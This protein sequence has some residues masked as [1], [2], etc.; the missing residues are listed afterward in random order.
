M[1]LKTF[2]AWFVLFL[3]LCFS[4]F[5][6]EIAAQNEFED[7]IIARV[8]IAFEGADTDI[9]ASNQ[10]R[11]IAENEVGDIY[12]TV[13]IRNALQKLYDTNR[14]ASARVEAE[15]FGANQVILRF[16]VK[17][18]TVAKRINVRVGEFTGESVTEQELLLRL[19]LSA[20]GSTITERI[21]QQNANAILTY[22]RD[23][24]FFEAE[25]TYTQ[26]PLENETEVNVTFNVL[27]NEQAKVDEF[28]LDIEKFD[29]TEV[30]QKIKLQKGEFF[31]RSKLNDDVERI[32][33]ALQDANFLAPRLNEPRVIYDSDT[34]TVD[35]ELQGEVGP[36]V[37]VEVDAG[38]EKVGDGTQT[39]LLP[40]RRE[41]TL[42]YSAIV[43]GDRR[44]ENY[45]QEKGYFFAE[46]TPV[47]SVEPKFTEEEASETENET[48][49]LCTA[50]SG[51]ELTD[52][53]VTVRYEVNLNRRLKLEDLRIEGTD[54]LTIEDVRSIL[55]SQ[56]ANIF[57][58]IP[59][60]GYGRGYTS[61]ELLQQDRLT[62]LSL[63][64]ELGYRNAQVAIRQGVSL[65]GESLIVTFLVREGIPTKIDSIEI[66]GNTSFSDA[67]LQTELPD[68][69]GKNFS[70]ARAR[71]SV[72][73]LSQFYANA[74]Y[75]DAKV[76]FEIEEIPD[77]E[78]AEFDKVK[79]IFNLENEGQK[80][81][82]NR[83][84]INGN[85]DTKREAIL[86]AIDLKPDKVLRQSDIFSSEQTL[87]STDAFNTVEIK[88]EP[89][90]ETPD[91][92]SRLS[93][94]IV[95]VTEKPPRLITYGGG[96]ST[97]VGL[98]GFFDI[99]HFNLFGKLQQG[100]ALVR[101][102]QRQQLVQVDFI[103]PR[104]IPDGKDQRGNQQ[105]APLRFTAQYQRD[106]TVTRFF[107]STFDQGTFGIVQRVD[108]NGN[109]I[110]EFG[111]DAGDPTLNRFTLTA[112]TN[113]TISRKDRTILFVKYRFE[114]VRLFNFESLLI[115]ELLRPDAKIRI[116]GFGATFVRDTRKNCAIKYTLIEIIERGEA[117]EPC[118]YSAGDPTDGDYLTAEYNFSAPLLGANIGFNKLQISYNR[119]YTVKPLR[120][121]TF[122]ARGI[123]GMAK[124]FSGDD[125]FD[126]TQFPGLRGSLPISERFFAGGSTT[127]R[128]FEFEQAGPRIV[129]VPEGIF[130]NRQGEEVFLSPFS[131]PFGGNALA[132]VNLEARVPFTEAIRV[133]PFYDGGNVFNRVSDIF[134]PT[135][136]DPSD[137][138]Q[139]NLRSVWTH[140]VGLGFRIKTPI[141]GEFAVDYGYLLNPPQF[142]IP[143]P[144]PPNAT[145]RL[146][147]GQIHFRFSQA[148]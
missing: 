23:R 10:F 51:A 98:S 48:E 144:V 43:E 54:K 77:E 45:F 89:A 26:Q 130:R 37:K 87:Y 133:V 115:K 125:R 121:T 17:R 72:R 80:V 102:S 84:L 61:L 95:N 145:L 16:V 118:R 111:N 4:V 8:D 13:S 134:N 90:G 106:S 64:R 67:T 57:G 107:R 105:F 22:L 142:T 55:E 146:H 59:F 78:N 46:A 31:T 73:K 136:A 135:D 112:E 2:P 79:L 94:V 119:Y 69:V 60:F 116:S 74:G 126:G 86:K 62:I 50:L 104:F 81:F 132:V 137:V 63:M 1:S 128:G 65:D 113:R 56:E 141:G 143:Q 53:I 29:K 49:V 42:D 36:T 66:N 58:F 120:N 30:L 5:V 85:E 108:E 71:N 15:N 76:S 28:V 6:S 148:F 88:P 35:I 3:F 33:L 122:A 117:G 52:R 83:V 34:N 21:L 40:I 131:I 24:G 109:P 41:G 12:S 99:R 123:L 25:V 75:Y 92:L 138:F 91:G 140:T 70:R 18:K 101:V 32:R 27:P 44:L 47:C 139:T 82:V 127:L 20:S 7:R 147:Q 19:N 103:N 129:V 38:R 96:F 14:I 11:S 100:G 124:V 97:D 93:D 114:D 110:D 39:R 68:L 9:S